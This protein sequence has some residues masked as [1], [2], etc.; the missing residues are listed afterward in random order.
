MSLCQKINYY[1]F[2]RAL[3]VPVTNFT[4]DDC[5]LITTAQKL[6]LPLGG[7]LVEV[8]RLRDCLGL[9]RSKIDEIYLTRP[10]E[11][12]K[13]D[14]PTFAKRLGKSESDP[15]LGQLFELCDVVRCFIVAERPRSGSLRKIDRFILISIYTPFAV[16]KKPVLRYPSIRILSS[17]YLYAN[18]G[19][20]KIKFVSK[21]TI[22]FEGTMVCS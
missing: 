16:R 14:L 11:I 1:Y 4:Y 22:K 18:Y 19:H 15:T 10:V 8:Q 5:R 12:G 3:G 20:L 9:Q 17:T 2:F 13:I 7:S 6:H 21:K